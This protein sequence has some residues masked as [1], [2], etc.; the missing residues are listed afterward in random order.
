[1]WTIG[2]DL[3]F[4]AY[5]D[6]THADYG[7][8]G[9]IS[10]NV[11]AITSVLFS[12]NLGVAP[13]RILLALDTNKNFRPES[14]LFKD[15]QTSAFAAALNGEFDEYSVTSSDVAFEE[16]TISTTF[17]NEYAGKFLY[18]LITVR[19]NG[20]ANLTWKVSAAMTGTIISGYT[21]IAATTTLKYFLLQQMSIPAYAKNIASLLTGFVTTLN[22]GFTAKRT[23]AGAA[24]VGL[25][26]ARAL[27]GTVME[28]VPYTTSLTAT[29]LY[30]DGKIYYV[31]A[32][33]SWGSA[34]DAVGG[35]IEFKPGEYNFFSIKLGNGSTWTTADYFTVSS[36]SITP[37]WSLL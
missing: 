23:V 18:P 32:T 1:M 28:F 25:D 14:E 10:G 26:T 19:D 17:G 35:K 5:C 12:R 2:G 29:N 30:E 4:D 15:F 11:P 31:L 16:G 34:L 21:P 20:G 27:F 6:A 8:I 33:T 24:N 22:I 3:V 9:G 13:V 37:R 7:V 36:A